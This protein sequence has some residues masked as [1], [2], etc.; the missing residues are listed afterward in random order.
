MSLSIE[1]PF[2][3]GCR[4]SVAP[5][6]F[7][8][9]PGIG[10]GACLNVFVTGPALDGGG[11]DRFLWENSDRLPRRDTAHANHPRSPR[12][13]QAD[14]RERSDPDSS[15]GLTSSDLVIDR[16]DVEDPDRMAVEGRRLEGPL[17]D[18]IHGVF[19]EP[20]GLALEHPDVGDL[21]LLV[22]DRLQDHRA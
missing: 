13:R 5:L 12:R 20:H 22:D 16:Q 1:P 2:R 6:R 19:A 7:A 8:V 3:S 21:P 14:Q 9:H 11:P 10:L 15:H 4:T 18:G 17:L